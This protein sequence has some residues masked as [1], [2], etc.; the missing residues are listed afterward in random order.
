MRI[1]EIDRRGFLKG[2]AGAATAAALPSIAK[3]QSNGPILMAQVRVG[4]NVDDAI[5]SLPDANFQP[6][7]GPFQGFNKIKVHARGVKWIFG[8]PTALAIS[9][10]GDSVIAIHRTIGKQFLQGKTEEDIISEI[11]RIFKVSK[12]SD[13]VGKSPGGNNVRQLTFNGPV[14]TILKFFY[15]PA[16]EFLGLT[17]TREAN[18][19]NTNPKIQ[20]SKTTT[21]N[22]QSSPVTDTE[23]FVNLIL[24]NRPN[25]FISKLDYTKYNDGVVTIKAEGNFGG[26]DIFSFISPT[27]KFEPKGLVPKM[28]PLKEL[29]KPWHIIFGGS[30]YS[31]IGTVHANADIAGNERLY[32]N[33]ETKK[34]SASPII[35]QTEEG[36]GIQ[37]F[38]NY[39]AFT[40]YSIDDIK[41]QM[42]EKITSKNKDAQIDDN[43]RTLTI[44]IHNP[45][46]QNFGLMLYKSLMGP[47]YS[48]M[49]VTLKLI[50]SIKGNIVK[51]LPQTVITITNAFGR[52]ESQPVSSEDV[53]KGL[54]RL[55]P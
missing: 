37:R 27:G 1:N 12:E 15:S 49:D 18:G 22:V 45:E 11:E 25:S 19:A 17:F 10:D 4:S 3:A 51:V 21:T 30:G 50:F 13:G 42:I 39:V 55:F 53:L 46:G 26:D 32:F 6:G 31:Q 48:N 23:K 38:D 29:E 24:R 47:R 34:L 43:G 54:E 44:K 5:K 2:L 52:T 35:K 41:D 40:G 28:S 20:I 8:I 7:P 16:N 36:K 33:N 14:D 9:T